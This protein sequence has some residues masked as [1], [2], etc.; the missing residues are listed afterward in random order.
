[1]KL[2]LMVLLAINIVTFSEAQ[3]PG[4]FI[5]FFGSLTIFDKDGEYGGCGGAKCDSH[6]CCCRGMVGIN[7]CPSDQDK[8]TKSKIAQERNLFYTI[9]W[10]LLL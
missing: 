6:V 9:G 3:C 2:L 7:N 10:R 4:F 5:H 1:M 8:S